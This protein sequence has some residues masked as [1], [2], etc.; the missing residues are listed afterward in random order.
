MHDDRLSRAAGP[1]AEAWTGNR[2]IPGLP[3]AAAPASDAEAYA[4]QD[5]FTE[6]LDDTVVGWKVGFPPSGPIT[7]RV[8]ARRLLASPARL[9]PE[10]FP[11]PKVE[12]EFALRLTS[13]PEVLDRPFRRA[14][15][16]D[17]LDCFLAIE[18]TGRRVEGAPHGPTNE[19]EVPDIVADNG[20]GAG[21]VVGPEVVRWQDR[22]LSE[23]QVAL[24]IAGRKVPMVAAARDRDPVEVVIWL[25]NHLAQRGIALEAGHY[26]STGSLTEPTDLPLGGS[27]TAVF[28]DLGQVQV[29]LSQSWARTDLS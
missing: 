16:V 17:R 27:A 11:D 28:G 19:G 10:V 15:F 12:C 29:E 2:P 9:S 25:A 22:P 14:D 5:R 4:V 21:L 26:V 1:L 3:A 7:G 6:L 23:T 24:T 18:M 20:A 13:A 8:F